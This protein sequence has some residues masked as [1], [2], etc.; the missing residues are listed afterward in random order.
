[1][2]Q[3]SAKKISERNERRSYVDRCHAQAT[4]RLS[5][6]LSIVLSAGAGFLPHL[7]I[8]FLHKAF[9]IISLGP[10]LPTQGV[11]PQH[12][13]PAAFLRP[14]MSVSQQA[15]RRRQRSATRAKPSASSRVKQIM[16]LAQLGF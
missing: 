16:E 13:I 12:E 14:I 1:M 2:Q 8:C 9:V 11:L 4:Q 3:A 6:G 7:H 10:Y 15:G 5:D